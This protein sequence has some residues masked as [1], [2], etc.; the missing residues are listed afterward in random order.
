KADA[1]IT[2][3]RPSAPQRRARAKGRS[4]EAQT[5]TVLSSWLASALKVRT[6]VA[7]VGVSTLGKMFSTTRLPFKSSSATSDKS[8]LTSLNEGA[9]LPLEG[10][11]PLVLKGF[12][13][14]VTVAIG[15]NSCCGDKLTAD[16]FSA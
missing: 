1:G 15:S 6:E 11:L 12:P 16:I 3:C 8:V 5:T 9:W 10:R 13:L 14:R 7:Q 4:W 2:L